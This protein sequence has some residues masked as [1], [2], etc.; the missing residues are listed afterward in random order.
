MSQF[1]PSDIRVTL[2]NAFKA[3]NMSSS[4]SGYSCCTFRFDGPGGG[5]SKADDGSQ[6]VG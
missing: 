6:G 3:L 5:G 4:L 2:L 1:D